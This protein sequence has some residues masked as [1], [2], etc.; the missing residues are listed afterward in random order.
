M[1][2]DGSNLGRIIQTILSATGLNMVVRIGS[3]IIFVLSGK[4]CL[5][6]TTAA[7]QLMAPTNTA[8]AME[9]LHAL[10]VGI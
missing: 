9:P 1:D 6:T 8:M 3:I 7:V 10:F 4:W 5:P 2:N